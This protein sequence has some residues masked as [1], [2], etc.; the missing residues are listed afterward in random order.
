[1][2]SKGR[3]VTADYI[4]RKNSVKHLFRSDKAGN[5]SCTSAETALIFGAQFLGREKA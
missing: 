5:Q 2:Y 3:M 1:M 4:L